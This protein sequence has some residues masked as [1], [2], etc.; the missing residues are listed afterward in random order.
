MSK[1]CITPADRPRNMVIERI[2]N[3]AVDSD[4]AMRRVYVLDISTEYGV[5][6][7]AIENEKEGDAMLQTGYLLSDEE[8]LDAC[9][10]KC[11]F[12]PWDPELQP[13]GYEWACTAG[14]W[15]IIPAMSVV[16]D[17]PD[18]TVGVAVAVIDT[19]ITSLVK[20]QIIAYNEQ[21]KM[22]LNDYLT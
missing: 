1:K 15:G 20:K 19:G 11:V 6:C 12:I 10:Q 16:D 5:A 2:Q 22:L 9:Q 18:P 17:A 3:K 7:A 13:Y 14:I 4:V 8:L 21:T